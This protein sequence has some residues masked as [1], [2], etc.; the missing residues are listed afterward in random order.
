VR[1]EVKNLWV[2]TVEGRFEPPSGEVRFDPENPSS[3]YFNVFVPV[4]SI[5]TGIDK[6]DQHLQEE[7][8][9]KAASHPEI[10]IESNRIS[11]EGENTYLF[12]GELSMAGITKPFECTFFAESS[13]DGLV[14][15]SKFTILRESFELGEDYSS[16]VIGDEIEI[17]VR[18][19]L[20]K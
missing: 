1:F 9:F 15:N 10:R 16:F 20:K 6:R 3:A 8:F 5:E 7:A 12:E 17:S 2:N 14:L 4:S 19:V 11:P 18:L 13:E